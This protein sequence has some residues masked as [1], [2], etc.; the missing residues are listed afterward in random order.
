MRQVSSKATLQNMMVLALTIALISMVGMGLR[1][2][3]LGS[4]S[5]W[6]DEA[7]SA[8]FSSRDWYYLWHEV[9][10][11]ETHPSFYYSLLKIWRVFGDDEFTLRLL[12]TAVNTATIP[13]VA[14]TAFLC[15]GK[16]R[17]TF[18]AVVTALLFACSATQLSASQDARPYVFTTLGLVIALLSAVLII[19]KQETA[20]QPVYVLKGPKPRMYGA[21]AGLGIGVSLMVWSHNLGVIFGVWLGVYL[22]IWWLVS[23]RQITLFFNLLFSA[24]VALILY[25]P[26]IPTLLMQ[27]GAMKK[28]GFWLEKPGFK[29]AL[30]ALSQLPLGFPVTGVNTASLSMLPFIAF[31]AGATVFYHSTRPATPRRALFYMLAVMAVA[32]A[33]TTFVISYVGQPVFLI[34]TLQPSQIP[35]LILM[36]FMP[37]AGGSLKKTAAAGLIVLAAASV[38]LRPVGV[39]DPAEDWR[40]LVL[41]IAESRRAEDGVPVV[42]VF[43]VEAELPL[44]YYAERLKIEMALKPIP[45][46]YPV[47]GPDYIYPSGAGS[48]PAINSE[49]LASIEQQIEKADRIW[50]VTRRPDLYDPDNRVISLLKRRFACEIKALPQ[51]SLMA[52][53]DENGICPEK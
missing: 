28:N 36:A 1:L 41:T 23:G 35:I 43:P 13:L 50:F 18:A 3:N 40:K 21:F 34:R 51:G 5:L 53:K 48:S 10:K 12:S 8:W 17:G 22:F 49:M 6:L 44:L 4:A 15:G 39:R 24:L 52:V 9:P 42:I 27:A 29:D 32:P 47:I 26:N 45:R 38:W 2:N 31:I 20:R 30:A 14:W 25:S 37:F 33:V 46:P 19:T 11:F 7:Y 16:E